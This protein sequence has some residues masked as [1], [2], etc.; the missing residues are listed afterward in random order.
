MVC[1]EFHFTLKTWSLRLKPFA[2]IEQ[3]QN[4]KFPPAPSHLCTKFASSLNHLFTTY[5]PSR[6]HFFT[7]FSSHL[8]ILCTTSASTLDHLSS[9]VQYRISSFLFALNQLPSA[10][11]TS[12]PPLSGSQPSFYHLSI[13]SLLLISWFSSQMISH[14]R[15][16]KKK[17]NYD[18]IILN[19]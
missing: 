6:H 15:R 7:T 17:K 10:F 12:Y 18:E 14:Q 8:H 16:Y 4:F 11:T 3:M 19:H 13:I 1:L 2:Q 9:V 5:A